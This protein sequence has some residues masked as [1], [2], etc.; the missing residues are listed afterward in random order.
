[1]SLADFFKSIFF[2]QPASPTP[3]EFSSLAEL[4]LF[5]CES[6]VNFEKYVKQTHDCDD[7]ARELQREAL[8]WHGGRILNVQLTGDGKHMLN[9]AI[10][11]NTLYQIEPQTDEVR[12]ICP[13]D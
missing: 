9:T 2:P 11:G 12:M 5:V 6:G 8:S 10:I 7:F 4:Y 13:L 3:T 1:M